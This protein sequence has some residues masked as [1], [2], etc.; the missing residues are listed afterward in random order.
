MQK[1]KVLFLT[2]GFAF[3]SLAYELLYLELFSLIVGSLV[4][5][6]NIL[7]SIF[8]FSLGIGSLAFEKI[9]ANYQIKKI[10]TFVEIG[11]FSLGLTSPIIILLISNYDP[12]YIKLCAY[13]I[14]GFIGILSGFELPIMFHYYKNAYGK[15]LAYDYIGMITCTLLFPFFFLPTLGLA[16]SFVYIT[17]TN[18]FLLVLFRI[19]CSNSKTK[20]LLISSSIY[21]ITLILVYHFRLSLNSVLTTLYLEGIDA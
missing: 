13:S 1:R 4:K 3:C 20:F 5:Q 15:L 19:Y 7:I 11:I 8:T 18:I 21:A 17:V 2:A 16:S 10:L 12:I 9:K 14:A 6:Y